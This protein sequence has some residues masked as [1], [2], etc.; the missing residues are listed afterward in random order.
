MTKFLNSIFLISAATL[1]FNSS[2]T[3]ITEKSEKSNPEFLQKDPKVRSYQISLLSWN[4]KSFGASKS[5]QHIDFIADI[6]KDFDVIALQEVVGK[7]GGAD[8]IIRL[9]QVLNQKY[10]DGNWAYDISPPTSGDPYKSERYAFLWQRKKLDSKGLGILESNY[11][12][13]IEREPYL[14]TFRINNKEFTIVNFHALPKSSQPETEIKYFKFFPELYPGRN[15]IFTGDFNTPQTHSVFNPL[16]KLGFQAALI[17]QKTT[18]RQD[19]VKGDCLASSF[20]NIF[21]NKKSLSIVDSGVIHFY[22]GFG[23]DMKKAKEISDHVPV[24]LKFEVK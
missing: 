8:A 5:N 22:R 2:F 11:Q 16:K 3:R 14:L 24:F 13:K 7:S 1:F 4:I 6:V 17:D 20:D 21:F 10:P 18:I 12:S 9:A 23:D 19:C 15:L